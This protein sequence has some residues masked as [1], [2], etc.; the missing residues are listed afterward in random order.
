M[1]QAYPDAEMRLIESSGGLFEVAVDGEQVFS[2]KKSRRH[3][4]PGEVL[5]AIQQLRGGK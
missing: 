3:A 4:E 5:R 2:K 1:K